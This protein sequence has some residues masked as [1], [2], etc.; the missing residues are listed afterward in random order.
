MRLN[1]RSVHFDR[2]QVARSANRKVKPPRDHIVKGAWLR[3]T[4]G[5]SE[6]RVQLL[7]KAVNAAVGELR[8]A[9]SFAVLGIEPVTESVDQFRKYIATNVAQSA[10]L[11][12]GAGFKPE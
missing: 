6:D 1:K 12:K 9:G 4:K 2:L 11:L 7:N 3:A 10:E 8:K 5:T